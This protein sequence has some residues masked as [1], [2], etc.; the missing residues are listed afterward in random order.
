MQQRIV[1]AVPVELHASVAAGIV[2]PNP[3]TTV[4]LGNPREPNT[5]LALFGLL[6]IS[7]LMAWRVRAA[8]LVA[9]SPPPRWAASSG[10]RTGG[11][12]RFPGRRCRPPR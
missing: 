3:H 11:R 4:A 1:A 8:M 9:S 5:L 12:S 10:W 7:A 2:V 6:V